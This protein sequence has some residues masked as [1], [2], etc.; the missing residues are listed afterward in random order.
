MYGPKAM[1]WKRQTDKQTD[2]LGYLHTANQGICKES[3]SHEDDAYDVE[4]RTNLPGCA[5]VYVSK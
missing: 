5:C 4:I 3:A 1:S 2:I